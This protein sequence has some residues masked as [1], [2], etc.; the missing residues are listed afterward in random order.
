MLTVPLKIFRPYHRPAEA[1]AGLKRGGLKGLRVVLA[2][3]PLRESAVPNCAPNGLCILGA[4][5]R[6]FGAEVSVIDL[7][8]YRIKDAEAESRGLKNGRYLSHRETENLIE[9]H[10][11]TN[12]VPDLFAL[13]GMITTLK[14]QEAV[15]QMV[16]RICPDTF[17]V[18]GNGLATE[19][20]TG[21]FNW[22][23]ELDAVAH[24]EGDF[25]I[26]KIGMDALAIKQLGFRRA[27]LAGKLEPYHL[28]EI[29]GRHR[30]LYDGGR[31]DDLDQV[32]FPAYDLI[33]RDVRGF[34]VLETYLLNQVWGIGANNSSATPFTMTRSINTVS[35]RGCPFACTFCFRGATGERNYG[36]R[37]A[38]NFA[39]E[40]AFYHEKYGVDFVG[41][42][43][44]NFMVKRGR[45]AD[46]EK[47]LAP[48]IQKT[49]LRWGT[50]GRLDE[51]ADLQPNGAGGKFNSPLRVDQM[52]R[53]GCVYIGFGA[54]SADK[55]TLEAMGKGGFILANGV[56]K[57][58]GFEFPRT[59]VEGIKN[60]K[61]SGIHANCT[62]IEAYP[63][64]TLQ[65]LKTTVAFIE[66]QKDF[67]AECGDTPDSVNAN[68]FIATAYPGTELFKDAR[69]KEIMSTNFGIRFNSSGDPECDDNL[70]YYVSELDDATKV[71][72][73][74]SGKPLNFSAM[75]EDQFL[76]TREYVECGKIEKILEME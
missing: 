50:H 22:I 14:W 37:S 8:V 6:D 1:I 49:A 46:I 21:L 42:T 47:I 2:N 65:Q 39:N 13:S 66:W 45:I 17:L 7:N 70:H 35:S 30:F 19:F 60:T 31:P 34:P 25:A 3:M 52:A 29:M 63:G 76:R 11:A 15:A 27:L 33:E 26:L 54:E 40:I 5:L 9:E 61:R 20:K 67:Y 75:T 28:G 24:S 44:D 69:V 74:Q 23:P 73:D 72:H 57:V 68:L 62:W 53:A 43:D 41:V 10:V 71:M 32:P 12:G 4:W 18:T 58:N 55:D 38:E 56:E 59:M 36:V 64:E 16:R 48:F 51:A